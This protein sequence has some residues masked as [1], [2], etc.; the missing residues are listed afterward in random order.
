M[1][2]LKD[3]QVS[4][5]GKAGPVQGGKNTTRSSFS[6]PSFD[7]LYLQKRSTDPESVARRE[8]L[9]E[10]RPLQGV[11]GK[12]FQNFVSGPGGPNTSDTQ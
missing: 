2:D 1:S 10:Q 5:G 3:N 9:A 7:N 8:S 12:A 6:G 11:I 4:T